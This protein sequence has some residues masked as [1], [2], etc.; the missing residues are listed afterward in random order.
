MKIENW[1]LF[2]VDVDDDDGLAKSSQ[3]QRYNERVIEC[4]LMNNEAFAEQISSFVYGTATTQS[5]ASGLAGK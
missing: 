2:D 3:E 5:E 4:C 1:K